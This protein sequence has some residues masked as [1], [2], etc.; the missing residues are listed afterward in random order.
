MDWSKIGNRIGFPL[1]ILVLLAGAVVFREPL[2]S[3]LASDIALERALA[4]TSVGPAPALVALQVLQV[5]VFIIPGEVVQI[6]AGYLFGVVPGAALSVLGILIGSV[7]NYWIGRALGR[8]FVESVTP[9]GPLKRIEETTGR[10][11]AQIGFF[12]LFVIPGIPKDILCYVAGAAGMRFGPFIAFSTIGRLPGIVGSAV[13]GATAAQQGLVPAAVLLG[14][15]AVLLVIG[16]NRQRQLER[17]LSR[18]ITRWRRRSDGS[19]RPD[20]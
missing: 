10:R 1:F 8:R 4:A 7:F 20:S 6:A 18:W 12:L 15:A 11:G 5:I 16:V 14:F 13:I 3:L 19:D 2:E 17:M 9:S